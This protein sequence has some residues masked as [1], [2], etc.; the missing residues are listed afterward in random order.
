M[1][2]ADPKKPGEQGRRLPTLAASDAHQAGC[3]GVHSQGAVNVS[4]I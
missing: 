1:F 2:V 3:A 4:T